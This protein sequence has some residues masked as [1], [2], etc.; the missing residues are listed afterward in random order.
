[1]LSIH[2]TTAQG[3]T[4]EVSAEVGQTLLDAVMAAGIDGLLGEC[5]GCCSCATC[6]C[7]I[8]ESQLGWLTAPDSSESQML[9][10]VA[11]ERL[12]G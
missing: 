2:V 7:M 1:M 9:D 12:A 8:D 4:L 11:T 10:F 6:H 3:A 5:G